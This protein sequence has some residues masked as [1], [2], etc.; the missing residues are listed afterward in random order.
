MLCCEDHKILVYYHGN[1]L[2]ILR[3]MEGLGGHYFV[4]KDR[5]NGPSIFKLI[6]FW[7]KTG[8]RT[9]Q[10]CISA[11]DLCRTQ[12]SILTMDLNIVKP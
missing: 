12:E 11:A 2:P 9:A 5:D 10:P 3:H 6:F 8:V 7:N 4:D 1:R